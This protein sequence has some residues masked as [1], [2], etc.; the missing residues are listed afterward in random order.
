MIVIFD[1]NPIECQLGGSCLAE[2]FEQSAVAMF[3]YM[4]E[5]PTVDMTDTHD[6]QV[7]A[8][9]LYSLYYQFL[10]EFLFGFCAEPYFIARV[11]LWSIDV[12]FLKKKS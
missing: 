9:D 4:T 7:E 11:G 6:I 12:Y 3:A 2:A 8:D 1:F 5:I 10:D